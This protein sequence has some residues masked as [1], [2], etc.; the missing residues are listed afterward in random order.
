M[1]IP[2]AGYLRGHFKDNENFDSDIDSDDYDCEIIKSDKEK[3]IIQNEA[4]IKTLI[5]CG[6]NVNVETADGLLPLHYAMLM[7][8]SN[9]LHTLLNTGKIDVN[10][11][12]SNDETLLMFAFRHVP[13]ISS[14]RPIQLSDLAQKLHVLVK[15]RL[16]LRCGAPSGNL[17]NTRTKSFSAGLHNC[18]WW[19]ASSNQGG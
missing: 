11:K 5:S 10:F 15:M 1:L 19:I 4:V 12:T 6:A 17:L 16:P 18:T 7:E 14:D 13:A 9:V 3:K 8:R 2:W